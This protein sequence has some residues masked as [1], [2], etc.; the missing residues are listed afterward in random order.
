M[1][2]RRIASAIAIVS[3][4][5]GCSALPFDVAQQRR[6]MTSSAYARL[7]SFYAELCAV[8]QIK[9]KSPVS[10]SIPV[11][12]QANTAKVFYLNGACSDRDAGYPTLVICAPGTPESEQGV[13]L[14][15]NAHFQNANW[16]ATAGRR[17]AFSS[18]AT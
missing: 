18:K 7:Y 12:A 6:P 11:A 15:V 16:V 4:L 14:S 9:E 1:R 2:R 10:A 17:D 3:W 8:S 5:A 13:G